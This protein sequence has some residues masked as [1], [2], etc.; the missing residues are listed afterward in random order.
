MAKRPAR[1]TTDVPDLSPVPPPAVRH[2]V[3]QGDTHLPSV[4]PLPLASGAAPTPS[5]VPGRSNAVIRGLIGE[6]LHSEEP[7]T[8]LVDVSVRIC[9]ENISEDVLRQIRDM[10]VPEFIE[11]LTVGIH[12]MDREVVLELV[13][14]LP[15][16]G[17]LYTTSLEAD[18]VK[19]NVLRRVAR[20]CNNR[21]F[22]E[23]SG[24]AERFCGVRGCY[25]EFVLSI[26]Q[27]FRVKGEVSQ[28]HKDRSVQV[29]Y[30]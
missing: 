16:S 14:A 12:D 7:I 21:W 19:A 26:P 8:A 4:H 6:R 28:T 17:R 2:H 20:R 25:L 30:M 11:E 1:C 27:M 15:G 10:V 22:R 18:F 5:D 24:G 9:H 29:T 3:A 23:L 13:P